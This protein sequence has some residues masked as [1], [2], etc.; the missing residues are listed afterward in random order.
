[1]LF[2]SFTEKGGKHSKAGGGKDGLGLAGLPSLIPYVKTLIDGV[3]N[4]TF[5]FVFANN[6]PYA[7]VGYTGTNKRT[8]KVY[9]GTTNKDGWTEEFYSE[10]EDEIEINLHLPWQDNKVFL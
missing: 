3:Y 8:G 7:N 5:Q 10:S 6:I 4:L 2:R 1:M 9:Q